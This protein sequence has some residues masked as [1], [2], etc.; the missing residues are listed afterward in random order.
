MNAQRPLLTEDL[1]IA[2]FNLGNRYRALGRPE[3]AIDAYQRLLDH[4]S[5]G[6]LHPELLDDARARL[7]ALGSR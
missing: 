2:Y 1:S 5:G 3:D 4:W 6:D 7:A